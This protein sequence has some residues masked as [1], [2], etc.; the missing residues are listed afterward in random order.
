M[1]VVV[2]LSQSTIDPERSEP[3]CAWPHIKRI[4][5]LFIGTFDAGYKTTDR[6]IPIIDVFVLD[7]PTTLSIG[8]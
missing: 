8:L 5:A 7:V 2:T 3:L 4:A 1:V 6:F